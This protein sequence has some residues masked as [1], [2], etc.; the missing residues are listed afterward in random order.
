[1]KHKGVLVIT[2]FTPPY[3]RWVTNSTPLFLTVCGM[4]ARVVSLWPVVKWPAS[5]WVDIIT[6]TS[7]VEEEGSLC[8]YVQLRITFYF[9][10]KENCF[11]YKTIHNNIWTLRKLMMRTTRSI[12]NTFA[13]GHFH[14]YI[15]KKIRT[16]RIPIADCSNSGFRLYK[17]LATLEKYLESRNA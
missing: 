11:K 12:I 10:M 8:S 14:L 3:T 2:P 7:P 6:K 13:I 17:N 15:A 5:R 9:S 1:M 16:L 4:R